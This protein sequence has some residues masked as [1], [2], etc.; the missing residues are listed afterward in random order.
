MLPTQKNIPL[1][2]FGWEI[3]RIFVVSMNLG[4]LMTYY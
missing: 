3:I 4:L 2:Y 1:S